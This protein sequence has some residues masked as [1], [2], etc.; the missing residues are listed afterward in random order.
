MRVFDARYTYSA[1]INH[2]ARHGG[3]RRELETFPLQG[4]VCIVDILQVVATFGCG[5]PGLYQLQNL[6]SDFD[7][8]GGGTDCVEEGDE[9]VHELSGGDLD[10]E[11]GTAV[12]DASVRQLCRVL[13][14]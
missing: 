8:H 13:A 10:E 5:S 7:I 12:L 4:P 2:T 3:P 9:I 1:T 11:M 6:G 14:S